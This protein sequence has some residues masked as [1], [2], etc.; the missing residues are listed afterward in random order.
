MNSFPSDR[1][2]PPP[3]KGRTRVHISAIKMPKLYTSPGRDRWPRDRAS[4]AR[5]AD[6]PVARVGTCVAAA[7][8]R[9]HAA[10]PLINLHHLPSPFPGG[11]VATVAPSPP[12]SRPKAK[13][14]IPKLE[15]TFQTAR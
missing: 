15:N 5:W 8:R 4:G 12:P 3:A 9:A 6:V 2:T 13:A 10:P 7:A 1:K 11:R 14:V